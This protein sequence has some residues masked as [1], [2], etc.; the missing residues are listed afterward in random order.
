MSIFLASE[1][2][3]SH[4]EESSSRSLTDS[5]G[6]HSDRPWSKTSHVGGS[7]GGGSFSGGDSKSKL[8]RGKKNKFFTS[9]PNIT[10]S[11]IN[12]TETAD[13]L[14]FTTESLPNSAA[15]IQGASALPA[16]ASTFIIKD[17]RVNAP[18]DDIDAN[19]DTITDDL[20]PFSVLAK[21]QPETLAQED[22]N[23]AMKFNLKSSCSYN[24][25]STQTYSQQLTSSKST[26][27][28]TLKAT[29]TKYFFI[30][31]TITLLMAVI[32]SLLVT[33]LSPISPHVQKSYP[34]RSPPN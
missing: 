10:C 22:N 13:S 19:A 9:S 18:N 21:A 32:L 1:E 6:T 24:S 4:E 11:S 20:V 27:T 34:N 30:Y 16:L 33:T 3:A 23:I 12:G 15:M 5:L 26:T 25:L 28:S 8:L 14:D 29:S 17:A 31:L 7:G 2:L